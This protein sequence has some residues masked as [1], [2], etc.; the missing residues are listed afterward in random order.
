MLG[1]RCSQS[2]CQNEK[3]GRPV[4]E[5]VMLGGRYSQSKSQN[6]KIGRPVSEHVMLG[7]RCSQQVCHVRSTNRPASILKKAYS[8]IN[9]QCDGASWHIVRLLHKKVRPIT[10]QPLFA[11]SKKRKPSIMQKSHHINCDKY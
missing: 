11:R 5:H 8:C 1:G 10:V 4:P 6:E 7:G 2:K 9:A 3:T